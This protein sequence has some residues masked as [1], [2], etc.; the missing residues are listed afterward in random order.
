MSWIGWVVL[1]ILAG[2]LANLV[3]RDERRR[4]CLT[5]MVTGV[6]GAVLAGF[7]YRAATGTPWDFRFNWA[8]IGVA[9]LGAIAL[10]IV[11]NLAVGLGR[12]ARRR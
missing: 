10:L 1:G 6:L 8:S 12:G 11:L 7:I 9:A 3:V 2:W 5:N 4:G